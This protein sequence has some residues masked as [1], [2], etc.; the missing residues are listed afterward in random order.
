MG[1]FRL[2][3]HF[4]IWNV[5]EVMRKLPSR[6]LT[7]WIAFFQ[8]EAEEQEKSTLKREALAGVEQIKSRRRK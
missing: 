4:K 5:D 1:M 2:C 6:L 7:E 8:L 3:K